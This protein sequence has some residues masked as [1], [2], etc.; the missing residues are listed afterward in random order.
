MKLGL[1]VKRE[2][3][4]LIKALLWCKTS[5]EQNDLKSAMAE[6]QWRVIAIGVWRGKG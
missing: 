6:L 5:L 2:G 3:L 4:N 1:E